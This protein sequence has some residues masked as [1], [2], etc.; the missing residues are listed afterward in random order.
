MDALRKLFY[1]SAAILI[2]ICDASS[3]SEANT[4]LNNNQIK[5]KRERK[6]RIENREKRKEKSRKE[7]T[8]GL[9]V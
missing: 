8:R 7:K 6:K 3:P 4:S 9:K 2:H 1:S 5:E